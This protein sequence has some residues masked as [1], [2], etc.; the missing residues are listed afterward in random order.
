METPIENPEAASK[1]RQNVS[2]ILRLDV[3][4]PPPANNDPPGS[5]RICNS[6]IYGPIF[7]QPIFNPRN[8]PTGVPDDQ[9]Q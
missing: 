6:P 5:I 8:F 9:Q 1:S 3:L 7:N 2:L 4:N